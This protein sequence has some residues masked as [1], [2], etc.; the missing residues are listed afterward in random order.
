MAAPETSNSNAERRHGTVE[1]PWLH[2]CGM[3]KIE[4]G[5]YASE[6]PIKPLLVRYSA[7]RPIGTPLDDVLKTRTMSY[8][9]TEDCFP[10]DL[11]EEKT[12]AHH[13]FSDTLRELYW[14]KNQ[15]MRTLLKLENAAL[16]AVLKRIIH[17]YFE[18]TRV[19]VYS[20]E[21]LFELMDETPVGSTCAL[22]EISCRKAMAMIYNTDKL[23]GRDKGIRLCVAEFYAQEITLLGY[24]LKLAL[25]MG[26][27]DVARI[28]GEM[29]RKTRASFEFAFPAM[30]T[31]AGV[32]A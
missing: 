12:P 7:S 29:Q 19:Q 21:H 16:N 31:I 10:S 1:T 17:D 13:V 18:A 20:I 2:S 23:E 5:K 4:S 22:T 30:P 28:I 11:A 9:Y 25:S 27:L 3:G 15:L 24:L 8:S 14:S 32:A 6:Q 26:R